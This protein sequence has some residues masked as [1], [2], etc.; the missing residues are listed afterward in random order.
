MASHV[1]AQ[2][3]LVLRDGLDGD[4]YSHGDD[5]DSDG[6]GDDDGGAGGNDDVTG[7]LLSLLLWLLVLDDDDGVVLVVMMMID[8]GTRI[9]ILVVLELVLHCC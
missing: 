1:E 6:V 9:S 5:G 8:M 2:E 4:D 7:R 3:G